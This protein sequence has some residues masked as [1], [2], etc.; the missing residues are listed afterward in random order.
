MSRTT[1]NHPLLGQTVMIGALILG[2]SLATPAL[3]GDGPVSGYVETTWTIPKDR[4]LDSALTLEVGVLFEHDSGFYLGGSLTSHDFLADGASFSDDAAVEINPGYSMSLSDTVSLDFGMT[5]EQA[6]DTDIDANKEVYIGSSFA[7]LETLG[8]D[9]YAY[10][11]IDGDSY[12]ELTLTHTLNDSVELYGLLTYEFQ[13]SDG[14]SLELGVVK[15]F[16]GNHAI[17]GAFIADLNEFDDSAVE[18]VYTYN[19]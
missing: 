14:K 19:F 17:S 5:Y 4:D 12:V 1:H 13:D 9:A 6:L 18:F 16:L 11:I 10:K 7:L 3:A 8:F 15:S 2:G